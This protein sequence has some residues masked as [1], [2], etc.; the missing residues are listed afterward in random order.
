MALLFCAGI[1]CL[2]LG[3]LIPL[4]Q[5]ALFHWPNG[6]PSAAGSPEKGPAAVDPTLNGR[7]VVVDT[8]ADGSGIDRHDSSEAPGVNSLL[9]RMARKRTY[10]PVLAEDL[11]PNCLQLPAE[12]VHPVTLQTDDGLLLNGWHFLADGHP[13]A[14]RAGC[15]RELS[16]GRP[17]ALYFPGNSGHRG[18][19]V[20]EAALLTRVGVDVF[21]FDY[22][23]YGDNPGTPG[24]A[25]FAADARAVWTYATS[26]R[27]IPPHRILLY[28]ESIGGAVATRL[29]SEMCV[30]ST[31][32]AGLFIRSTTSNLADTARHH[33]PL[34][35]ARLLPT[36]RY[37]AVEHIVQVTSPIVMLHGA[38]D[39]T[40]P[41]ALGHKVFDAAP[42]KSAGGTPKRF[43]DLP[44]SGHNDVVETDGE[45]LQS[46]LRE[47][48]ERLFPAR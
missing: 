37:A 15:D 41:S 14:D 6:Q 21:L 9:A 27:R 17:L 3:L 32:P 26:E 28:G 11:A 23:G 16:A 24:E 10:F 20:P 35:P 44:H 43:V 29:A 4:V 34:L 5:H 39:E 40:I 46:A 33:Y 47:F 8:A 7:Q 13:A 12:R 25:A 36:E 22:R 42:T 48:V 45:L 31:P 18:D 2:G 1:P 30:A 19:R 38:Q